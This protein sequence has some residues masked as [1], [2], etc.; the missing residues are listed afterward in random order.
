MYY[1]SVQNIELVCSMERQP[2]GK[3]STYVVLCIIGGRRLSSNSR[4]TFRIMV[5]EMEVRGMPC[6]CVHVSECTVVCDG[7]GF[8]VR[9]CRTASCL[10]VPSFSAA[11]FASSGVTIGLGERI[12]GT[13]EHAKERDM[14]MK[15]HHSQQTPHIEGIKYSRR[16][17]QT[18]CA[19]RDNYHALS[20]S[21][22][23]R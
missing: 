13:S 17:R 2:V 23:T 12:H 7:G 10:E 21:P 14:E 15:D 16:T 3:K 4:W 6:T 22:R 8:D 18:T 1:L 20:P 11:I 5:E 9:N 19:C